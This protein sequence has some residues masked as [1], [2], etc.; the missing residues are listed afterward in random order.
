MKNNK[1]LLCV[2]LVTLLFTLCWL[3]MNIRALPVQNAPEPDGGHIDLSGMDLQNTVALLPLAWDYYPGLYT[4][5]EI[6][7]GEAGS[8]RLFTP[9]DESLQR[10]GTY[11]AVLQIPADGLYGLCAWSLDYA[12]RIY[13]DGE[14]IFSVGTV[15][16][17]EGGFVPGMNRYVVPAPAKDGRVEIVIQ[18]ANFVH[19][20]GGAMREIHFSTYENILQ[21]DRQSAVLTNL[22]SGG[23]L[24]LSLFYVL[25]FCLYRR[26]EILSFALCC[27]ALGLRSQAFVTS[28]LPPDYDWVS[29]YK[30]F[31]CGSI[32][33]MLAAALL[34]WAMYPKRHK[35]SVILLF[36][37]IASGF[38][39]TALFAPVP[40]VAK[41]GAPAAAVFG[42][43][44]IYL[45]VQAVRLFQTKRTEHRLA[46]VGLLALFAALLLD[47]LLM[48]SLPVVTRNG[49]GAFGMLVFVLC[50]MLALGIRA[51]HSAVELE[52]QRQLADGYARM[53]AMKTEFLQTVTHELKTPLTVMS[54]CAQD[55]LAILPEGIPDREDIL[56]NQRHI[57]EESDRLDRIVTGLLDTAAIE[58]GRMG[59]EMAPLSLCSL[60]RHMADAQFP[61][62]PDHG[63]R[64][65]LLVPDDL[66]KITADKER[67]EQVLLN[68]LS[69]A[70]RHTKDGVITLELKSAP[71]HQQVTVRDTG[72]GM[73]ADVLGQ[74]FQ[75][76]VNRQGRGR[77][78]MG[79]YICRKILDA[80]GGGIEIESRPGCGTAVTFRLP[81][82]NGEEK[83]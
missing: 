49:L 65:E 40:V 58:G 47:V 14:E 66:P 75:S 12:T 70:N 30:F 54:G 64:L 26:T 34:P 13:A 33:M 69:N 77:S 44:S 22:S 16:P 39:V 29:L 76:Y 38:I 21:Y 31:F 6:A 62:L 48:R 27:L 63:N 24:L 59:M 82:G 67:M 56:Y 37:C 18:Y 60:L 7:A 5:A 19:P 2:T 36:L 55:T 80:H 41:L 79:L 61:K 68:L 71:D 11:R 78:G 42:L 81:A 35:R 43:V 15:T 45:T 20:E 10:T 57:I 28:L 1:I 83:R 8:P 25:Q 74:V 50:Y 32:I 9:E 51:E 3:F 46:A 73:N 23:L 4:S 17:Q 72:E 52:R 53:N